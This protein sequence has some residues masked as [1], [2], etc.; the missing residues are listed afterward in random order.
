MQPH[1]RGD[2]P[3]AMS[4]VAQPS[5]EWSQL[6]KGGPNGIFVVLIA[7]GWWFLAVQVANSDF[8]DFHH[9]LADVQWALEQTKSFNN[10]AKRAREADD[11][12][13]APTTSK[14]NKR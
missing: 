4:R 1:F 14:S 11:E 8:D 13:A 7:M 5:I 2:E 12:S 3:R 6:S 9:A 10:S